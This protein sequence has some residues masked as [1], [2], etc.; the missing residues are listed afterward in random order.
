MGAEAW[1]G[2]LAAG[3]M[4]LTLAACQT[5]GPVQRSADYSGTLPAP[6]SV[7]L[8]KVADS[9]DYVHQPTGLVLSAAA[10]RLK[11]IDVIE[12]DAARDDVGANYR[13]EGRDDLDFTA[14]I[15]PIWNVAQGPLALADVPQACRS[16]YR[17]AKT[18]AQMRLHNPRQISE[19]PLDPGRFGDAAFSQSVLFDADGGDMLADFPI[20]S[21]LHVHCGVQK[22]WV[23]QYRM[24]YAPNVPNAA[25]LIEDFMAAVPLQP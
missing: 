20:R 21:E 8:H 5:A 17:D 2:R 19:T 12:T 23:V 16:A 22:V 7:S 3:V 10:G 14:L 11:R 13:L 18:A 4:A 6:S 15:L 1:S 25:A 24:S 9:A